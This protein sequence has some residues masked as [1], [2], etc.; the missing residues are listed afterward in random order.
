MICSRMAHSDDSDWSTDDDSD[1]EIEDTVFDTKAPRPIKI[2]TPVNSAKFHPANKIFVAGDFDGVIQGTFSV[3]RTRPL[4]PD[5][6]AWSFDN[7]NEVPTTELKLK[8]K[9]HDD[10]IRGVNFSRTGSKLFTIG[11]DKQL[12]V[13]DVETGKAVLSITESFE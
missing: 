13:S 10:S 9:A 5:F 7:E 1:G 12:L 8:G 4:N 3:C 2:S 6:L 11:N